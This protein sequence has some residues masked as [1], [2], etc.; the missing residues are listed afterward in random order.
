MFKFAFVLLGCALSAGAQMPEPEKLTL[1]SISVDFCSCFN[2]R[3]AALDAHIQHAITS[4]FDDYPEAKKRVNEQILGP[5]SKL[6]ECMFDTM[7][8]YG[9]RINMT[10]DHRQY[11]E[12]RFATLPGCKMFSLMQRAKALK[13]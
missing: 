1:D 8:Q 7:R 11:I 9:S 12:Q 3:F 2:N 6:N 10:A 13:R 5:K 4:S